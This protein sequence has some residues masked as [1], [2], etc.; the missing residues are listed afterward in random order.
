MVNSM[1]KKEAQGKKHKVP[2]RSFATDVV[3]IVGGTTTA[4]MI[5]ILS[6]LIVAKLYEPQMVG[7]SSLFAALVTTLVVASCLRYEFSIMLPKTDE[8]ATNLLALSLIINL[9]FSLAL[10]PLLWFFGNDLASLLNSPE[11]AQYLW[12]VPLSVFLTGSYNAINYWNSRKR[13]FGRLSTTQISRAASLATT[14]V[15]A[16]YAGYASSGALI[17]GNIV[18]Q[19]V[20]TFSLGIRIFHEYWDF[21]KRSLD[22]KVMREKMREYRDFP[23]FDMGSGFINVLSLQIPIFILSFYFTKEIVG[24]YS[25]GLMSVQMPASLVGAA[26]SKVFYQRAAAAFH[27]SL[28]KMGFIVEKVTKQLVSIG[29]LPILLLMFIGEDLFTFFFGAKWAE[30][31]VYAEILAFWT[32]IVFVASPLS[33]ILNVLKKM[34]MVLIYNAILI[35]LRTVSLAYGGE[36]GDIY[37]S[38][39]LF[40]VTSGLSGLVLAAWVLKTANVSILHLLRSISGNVSIAL[41]LI[42]LVAFCQFVLNLPSLLMIVVGVAV[43]V[44]YY[45]IYI[46]RDDE[47]K[48]MVLSFLKRGKKAAD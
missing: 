29:F 37:L 21:L 3:T 32:L 16:G 19:A 17:A 23:L 33:S 41:M 34:R 25:W 31:G 39:T 8:E 10:V 11:I 5:T 36:M 12:L 42:G 45:S 48:A 1:E 43:A 18:G 7:L 47:M 20:A 28:E 38:L 14:Q 24:Y 4:Q 27:E 46:Y 40:S 26:I 6:A 30:A 15:G 2:G 9:T 35:I 22:R 13:Q 44:V